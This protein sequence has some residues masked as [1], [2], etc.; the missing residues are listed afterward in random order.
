ML[1]DVALNSSEILH[2][3]AFFNITNPAKKF[4]TMSQKRVLS[5]T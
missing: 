4:L 3:C 2:L 5:W 1:N